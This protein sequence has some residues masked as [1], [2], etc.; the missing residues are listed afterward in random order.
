MLRS[1]FAAVSGLRAHQT[2]MD[3]VGNNIA[4]VNTTGFKTSTVRVRGPAQPDDARRRRAGGGDRRWYEP[5][6]GRSR[7]AARRHRHELRAGRVA[8]RPVARPTSPIQGD[9]FFVVDQGGIQA[10][11][12]NGSF[13]L[14][15][16]GQLVTGDGGLVQ[17]WQADPQ[18]QREHQLER[19]AR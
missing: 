9:G 18:G 11:T 12:R 13:S 16:I 4:N 17:G 6:A 3:V 19:R 14:D 7:C 10:Y 1:M 2:F 8:A 15:G 5:R